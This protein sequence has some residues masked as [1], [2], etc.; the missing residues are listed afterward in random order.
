MS[1][2]ELA[3]ACTQ[4]SSSQQLEF[5][6]RGAEDDGGHASGADDNEGGADEGDDDGED[7][8]DAVRVASTLQSV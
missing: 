8:G 3:G 4:G 1:C 7:E 6:P 5:T 2:S